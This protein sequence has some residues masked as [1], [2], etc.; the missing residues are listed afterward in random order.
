[1]QE[2]CDITN[3]YGSGKTDD[4][5]LT[6]KSGVNI[7]NFLQYFLILVQVITV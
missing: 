5:T 2:N 6:A 7:K 3:I 1:M 4:L